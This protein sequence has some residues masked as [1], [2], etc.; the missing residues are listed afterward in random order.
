MD[1][2]MNPDLYEDLPVDVTGMEGYMEYGAEMPVD[3]SA[4]AGLM[5]ALMGFGFMFFLV[6]SVI[7]IFLIAALWKVF[8]KAGQPGWAAIIPI[9]NLYILLK[10]ANKPGWW[11]LLFIIPVVNL[12]MAIIVWIEVAKA[13][14]KSAGYGLGLAFL[15]IIFLPM[16]GF[17]SARYIGRHN[18]PTGTPQPPQQPQM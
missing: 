7:I 18:P 14:G 4:D 16:L 6:M 3:A 9:Y 5:I 11:L 10:I 2:T 12:V 13:F 17:G 1:E 15:G 8:R